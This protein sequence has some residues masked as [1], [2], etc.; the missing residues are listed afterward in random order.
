MRRSTTLAI[1][2]LMVV[3]VAAPAAADGASVDTI[4]DFETV[5]AVADADNEF[6]VLLMYAQCD[7][8][9]RVE[10]PDGT[11]KET[12]SCELTEPFDI[13][14][15][16]VPDRA[17]KDAGGEC[18]WFSDYWSNTTGDVFYA[19]SYSQL[20]TPSGKVHATS[21]YPSDPITDE[22]CGF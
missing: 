10:L 15:G 3:L 2:M 14:P 5:V 16:E 11:S 13:F 18:I 19:S 9:V 12:M 1:A 17:Y 21:Q 6:G 7:F 20:V 8:L 22:D 4:T